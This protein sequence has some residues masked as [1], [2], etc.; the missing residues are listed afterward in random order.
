MCAEYARAEDAIKI[1]IIRAITK[2]QALFDEGV[3]IKYHV[4]QEVLS[5]NDPFDSVHIGNEKIAPS[6]GKFWKAEHAW[7]GAAYFSNTTLYKDSKEDPNLSLRINDGKRKFL[8]SRE[9]DS[10]IV[11]QGNYQEQK[12]NIAL[13][14][15]ELYKEII[16]MDSIRQDIGITFRGLKNPIAYCL[17]DILNEE[18]LIIVNESENDTVILELPGLD[19]IWLRPSHN[20]A[21]LRR[22]RNWGQDLPI[23]VI[24][25]NA[26]FKEIKT[27]VWIPMK[28]NITYY[29]NPKAFSHEPCVKAVLSVDDWTLSLPKYI[30]TPDVDQGTLVSDFEN[31]YL[32]RMPS[33]D[34]SS[35]DKF[36]SNPHLAEYL[37][38]ENRYSLFRLVLISLGII[39]ILIPCVLKCYAYYKN[40]KSKS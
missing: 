1:Q 15:E 6:F 13:P 4:D 21:V 17:A 2:Q 5:K 22:E 16:G 7:K 19:R 28:S 36:F 18:Q 27:G 23:R 24:I 33:L 12:G 31:H 37:E 10:L 39:M 32:G 9:A 29:S 3:M 20:F 38:Q 30:F 11:F 35:I 8:V 25:D 26:N 34:K 40:I 14:E